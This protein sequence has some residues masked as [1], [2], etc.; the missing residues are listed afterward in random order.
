MLTVTRTNIREKS[1]SIA[2][3]RTTTM[4]VQCNN[5]QLGTLRHIEIVMQKNP[6]VKED[7]LGILPKTLSNW[8]MGRSFIF[9]VAI[10]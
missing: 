3:P 9:N 1:G 4:K 2:I 8:L 6:L 7:I 5:T 10:I